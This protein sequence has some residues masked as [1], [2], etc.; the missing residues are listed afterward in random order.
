LERYED[1]LAAF[2]EAIAID[3]DHPLAGPNIDIAR[4]QLSQ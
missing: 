4:Q 3:P 2:E 1:A